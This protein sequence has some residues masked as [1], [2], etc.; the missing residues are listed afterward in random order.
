MSARLLTATSWPYGN[1]SGLYEGTAQ[2]AAAADRL[3]RRLSGK[4]SGGRGQGMKGLA[5]W[6]RQGRRRNRRPL[7]I[8]NAPPSGK[9]GSRA[10]ISAVRNFA[11]ALN[12]CS[13][14]SGSAAGSV[15]A[16]FNACW[17]VLGKAGPRCAWRCSGPSWRSPVASG[18]VPTCGVAVRLE[19]T[20]VRWSHHL[21]S[22]LEPNTSSNPDPP[23]RWQ[24]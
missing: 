7:A 10:G 17:V 13:R 22:A 21:R 20:A 2:Q 14:S 11:K 4:A 12:G 1:S 24:Q 5:H 3:R 18:M 23:G 6:H 16:A 19:C 15:V 8:R 9:G